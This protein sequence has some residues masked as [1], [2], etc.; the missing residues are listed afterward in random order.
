MRLFDINE[1]KVLDDMAGTEHDLD[2]EGTELFPGFAEAL[3]NIDSYDARLE[4][5]FDSEVPNSLSGL[6]PFESSRHLQTGSSW[7]SQDL[8]KNS[9]QR[10]PGVFRQGSNQ[11]DSLGRGGLDQELEM[12]GFWKPKRFR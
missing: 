4:S 8:E 7:R 3:A 10:S 12:A 2:I 5:H 11:S 1:H 9:R 6:G